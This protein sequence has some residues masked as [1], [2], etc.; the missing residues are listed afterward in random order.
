VAP[1]LSW[2]LCSGLVM[3]EAGVSPAALLLLPLLHSEH[4]RLHPHDITVKR[5]PPQHIWSRLPAVMSLWRWNKPHLLTVG[6]APVCHHA[7]L[8]A[9]STLATAAATTTAVTVPPRTAAPTATK[10]NAHGCPSLNTDM[11]VSAAK[12][13]LPTATAA[14][15]NC[16]R[17]LMHVLLCWLG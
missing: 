8:P 3:Q 11:A 17:S 4:T 2:P 1:L 6:P 5:F 9:S 10:R 13:P 16:Y 14:A 15:A 12:A 7:E